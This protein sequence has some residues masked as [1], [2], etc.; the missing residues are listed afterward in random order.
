MIPPVARLNEID[1]SDVFAIVHSYVHTFG[2]TAL[3][4]KEA[5]WWMEMEDAL[6]KPT[7]R[8]VGTLVVTRVRRRSPQSRWVYVR[9]RNVAPNTWSWVNRWTYHVHHDPDTIL[10][11]NVALQYAGPKLETQAGG[12]KIRAVIWGQW[13]C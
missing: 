11:W 13:Q 5:N 9:S 2:I 1:D 7:L 6:A 4:D 8:D 10:T 12:G 3:F